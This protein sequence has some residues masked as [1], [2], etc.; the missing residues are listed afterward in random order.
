MCERVRQPI[1]K[2]ALVSKETMRPERGKL[3][4]HSTRFT[5]PL[6]LNSIFIATY[7]RVKMSTH[8]DTQSLH[9]GFSSDPATNSCDAPLYRTTA[10]VF[11]DTEHAANL[12][13]LKEL[14]NIYTRLNNPTVDILERTIASIEGGAAAV[15]LASGT[16]AVFY[17]I[18]NL[19]QAGDEIV[20]SSNLYGGSYTQFNDILPQLGI[21]VRFVDPSNPENFSQAIN[22][23]TRAVFTE[24][25]GN[26][27]LDV[28]DIRAIS[29]VAHRH[30][31]PLI[32][33][34]TFTAGLFK[35]LDHGADIA[36]YSLT[37]WYGGHGS[38]VGGV[39]VDS[40]RFNW[41]T[42]KHPLFAE[43]EASYN[44]LRFGVDLPEPLL[45]VAYALR[46]RLV[47]LRN[48]GACISPDNAWQFIQGIKT[49]A[50]R[51]KQHSD[52]ALKVAEYLNQRAQV[53]WVRYPGLTDHASHE[54]ALRQFDGGFGA[55]V[56]FELTGGEQAGKSFIERLKLFKHVANVG[57]SKS[58][59]I[60]PASTTH[61]QLTPSQ[62]HDAGISAGLVR[63][64]IGIEHIDDIIA[65]IEQAFSE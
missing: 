44:G 58:L 61:S 37:K 11:N 14:G 51:V 49:L 25:I 30:G 41:A 20:A 59:A 3:S 35:P 55:T 18:I 40:G 16:A 23:K 32:V 6:S 27:S 5:H 46:L 54:I 4:N 21:K 2:G 22:E 8:T 31:L 33:D 19:A 13:A 26:P 63:L 39:V 38:G 53:E 34:A 52:N 64:S 57:D 15:A 47:P 43:P 60:H 10:Y 56:V 42:D 28:A 12:F 29:E 45:P 62:Q 36:V 7:E 24:S 65:D 9:A 1:N 17:S 48:L 50:L